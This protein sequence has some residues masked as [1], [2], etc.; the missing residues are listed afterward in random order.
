MTM[1]IAQDGSSPSVST[2]SDRIVR[3]LDCALIYGTIILIP[4]DLPLIHQA[5]APLAG[6]G[7]LLMIARGDLGPFLAFVRRLPVPALLTVVI[8]A[9]AVLSLYGNINAILD[10]TF[11][12]ED[13][14]TRG[15]TQLLLLFISMAYPFYLAFCLRRH[16]D[17]KSLIVRAAWWSLPVPLFVGFLQLANVAGIHGLSHLPYVGGV[18]N[19]GFFRLTSVARES[20]WFGSFACVILPFLI[21]SRLRAESVWRKWA[22]LGTIGNLLLFVVFGLSKSALAALA[23]EIAVGLLIMLVAYRPMRKIGKFFFG[24]IVVVTVLFAM[25]ILSPAAFTKITAPF[26]NKA[27]VVY[28]LFEP[29][30]KQNKQLISIS[31]RFGMSSAGVSMGQEHPL[32][33]VGLGQFGFN[34]YNYI[35]LWGLNSETLGW[36]SNDTKGWPSTSNLYTRLLAEIGGPGFAAYVVFRL[37]L[38]LGVGARLLRKGSGTWSRDLAVFSIMSALVAFDF[39]RDSF[40]NLDMWAALGMA[41]ACMHETV[42]ARQG[43]KRRNVSAKRTWPLFGVVAA[44]SF[45]VVMCVILSR[46]V[47][48]QASAAVLPKSSGIVI[49]ASAGL[50]DIGTSVSQGGD[51]DAHFKLLRVFWAS[52]TVAAR[53]IAAHPDLVRAVLKTDEPVTPSVLADYIKWNVTVLM[54]DNQTTLTFQY[55]NSDPKLADRFLVAA[56]DETDH[57]IAAVSTARRAQAAQFSQL[58][59]AKNLDLAASQDLLAQSAARE[60]QSDF[61]L[62]GE[63]TSF[64]YVEHPAVSLLAFSPQPASALLFAFLLAG[65]TAAVAAVVRL[66]WPAFV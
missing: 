31:T 24:L 21:M 44:V 12:R 4:Y 64:D 19:G 26:V 58:I 49:S 45:C 1:V 56:I 13:G 27:L 42:A 41:L 65:L 23:T 39:H 62:A 47:S 32:V 36:L 59:I 17:W 8:C 2:G 60:L 15:M 35:P 14:W 37:V 10:S 50:D 38:M 33:G 28:Q 53:I 22:A 48:Y 46:P 20:S 25:A 61:D 52:R 9:L 57:A 34:V 66:L 30:L 29:L 63:N 18:Y 5:C 40:I 54:E 16:A 55:R 11:Q 7:V 43:A 51:Q 6:I 3:L